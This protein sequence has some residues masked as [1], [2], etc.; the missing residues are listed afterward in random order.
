MLDVAVVVCIDEQNTVDS[1]FGC[2]I[3]LCTCILC[4]VCAA[5]AGLLAF[6]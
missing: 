3:L 2:W 1:Q 6:D 5:V 4:F